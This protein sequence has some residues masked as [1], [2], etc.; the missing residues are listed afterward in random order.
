MS[1]NVLLRPIQSRPAF[2]LC[3]I[4]LLS[5]NTIFKYHEWHWDSV[6]RYVSMAVLYSYVLT[7]LVWYGKNKVL[8]IVFYSFL[9]LVC[10][11]NFFLYFHFKSS[12]SPNMLLLIAETNA[13]E[14]AEFFSMYILKYQ[15]EVPFIIWCSDSFIKTHENLVS[16]VRKSLNRPLSLDNVCQLLFHL[17]AV[18][19]PAYHPDRDII[20]SSYQCPP[21]IVN[22]RRVH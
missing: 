20:S 1:L 18:R 11:V 12:I 16:S 6:V 5:Q 15:Y 10:L 7:W 14:A 8:K 22:D 4:A 19:T 13:N 9:L 21:R 2:M 3:V 17:G